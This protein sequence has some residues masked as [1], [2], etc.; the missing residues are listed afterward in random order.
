[1]KHGTKLAQ[2]E[3]YAA[4]LLLTLIRKSIRQESCRS[5]VI[6]SDEKATQ[7][8]AAAARASAAVV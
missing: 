8:A 7:G 6:V 1:M 5:A 2:Q 3:G 4:G